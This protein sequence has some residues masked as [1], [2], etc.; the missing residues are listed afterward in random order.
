METW[1]EHEKHDTDVKRI[2][3]GVGCMNAK[4]QL[5][6]WNGNARDGLA[7]EGHSSVGFETCKC[8]TKKKV[9]RSCR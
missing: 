2:L 8:N 7:N 4:G 5:V 1:E 9:W 3:K 6:K